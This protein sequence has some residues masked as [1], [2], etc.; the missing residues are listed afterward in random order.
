M[1]KRFLY[2]FILLLFYFSTTAQQK[3]GVI[4]SKAMVVSAYPDASKI[5]LEVLRKGG[6]AFDAM[7]ATELALAV[8]YPIAGN[9]GGGGFMVYRTY[10]GEYGALD[11]REKAPNKASKD[12]YLDA[13]GN[14]IANLSLDSHL[15]AG[16][17]G[18][19]DGLWTAHQRFGTLPFKDLVQP[20]IDLAYRGVVL[21]QNEAD[22]LNEYR[23]SF[24]QNN[25]HTPH[26]V[27]P[28]GSLWKAG[29]T[30][31]HL[32]LA[33]T[34]ERIRDKGREGFYGGKT[35]ELIVAQ[36]QSPKTNKGIISL[37]DLKNYKAAWRIPLIGHYKGYRI[38][39]MPPPSAGG[40]GLVQMLNMVKKFP[41]GEWGAHHPK[42][43]QAMVEAERR[44]YADRATYIGDPDF[45]KV[46]I[47]KLLDEKY[48]AKR[49]EDFTPEKATLSK[50]IRAGKIGRKESEETTHYSIVDAFGNA[51]AVTTTLNDNYGSKIM[52]NGAGFLLN[53]EMDDFSSKTGVPNM[54]GVIGG[55]ANAIAPN[56]RMLSS[57]TPTILEKNNKLFM[58]VGTPGGST[59]TTSVFQVILNVIE[60]N[61]SLQEAI[62]KPRFHHQWL[63]D[64]VYIEKNTFDENTRKTL[65]KWGYTLQ[66]RNPIGKVNGILVLPNGR[67]EGGADNRK[68]DTAIG[69]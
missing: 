43:I 5:G 37:E 19:V 9:I 30:L 46:P 52:V 53:N 32:D 38:I 63:P 7:V 16:V 56:K 22:G 40:I 59:I 61:M 54:F 24:V 28:Q 33:H 41:L 4:A 50:N 15:A 45:Y 6:N 23:E 55:K 21:T 64:L 36:M 48:I 66:E 68:D 17:P 65:S 39:S 60:F 18:T 49:I 62:E 51:I 3:Q 2:T 35:A 11:Y 27:K 29:D 13:Q 25:T 14:V 69:Y 47:G 12:M 67:L 44:F 26:W 31:K 42:S 8:C 34:L 1:K 58:V 10:K 57:M 20:A